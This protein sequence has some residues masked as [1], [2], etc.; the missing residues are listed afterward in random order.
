M[1]EE[2]LTAAPEPAST[3]PVE[4]PSTAPEQT[5]QP[6]PGTNEPAAPAT[7]E[8]T[9]PEKPEKEAWDGNLE[10]LKDLGK[11]EVERA[12]KMRRYLTK[13]TQK[14]AEAKKKAEEYERIKADPRFQQFMSGNQQTQPTPNQQPEQQALWTESEWQEAQVNP[15]KMAELFE[16][17]VNAKVQEVA[18]QY[19]PVIQELEKKQAFVERSAEIQDFASIHPD[20]WDL[21]EAGI[22]KPL[23]REIVDT[24]QGTIADAYEKAKNIET[25]FKQKAQQVAQGRV[26]EKKAAVAAT[27]S[28]AS[29]PSVI[30]AADREEAKRIA[31]ENAL[32]GKRVQV[33]TRS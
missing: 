32:L 16:R 30:W 27:P 9:T 29:E 24:G 7:P 12:L 14:L 28:P 6:N 4:S 2:T 17:G 3:E 22:M 18:S 13:E 26:L 11:D 31:F 33:K 20:I 23:V 10:S 15:S 8:V 19:A 25:F 1:A 21:Y 5:A